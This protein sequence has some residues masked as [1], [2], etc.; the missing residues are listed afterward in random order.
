MT[1]VA[2]FHAFFGPR[3]KRNIID[4]LGIPEVQSNNRAHVPITLKYI[5]MVA[6]YTK[7]ILMDTPGVYC[8]SPGLLARS[9]A[10]SPLCITLIYNVVW[11][12]INPNPS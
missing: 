8:L 3:D 2:R 7:R 10:R 4:T 11:V 12:L 9:L 1:F 5:Y 6:H